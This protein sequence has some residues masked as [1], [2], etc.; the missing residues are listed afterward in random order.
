MISGRYLKVGLC[1]LGVPL[2]FGCARIRARA[3][4]ERCHY[5]GAYKSGFNDAQRRLPMNPR[6]ADICDPYLQPEVDQGYNEGYMYYVSR[7]RAQPR[8]VFQY[9]AYASNEPMPPMEYAGPGQPMPA[10]P[11][12]H[13][14][15]NFSNKDCGFQCVK[16]HTEIA[17]SK[18]LHHN[19]VENFGKVRCGPNCRSH[20][21][22]I[23][24]DD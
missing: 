6:F 21:S 17:C 9:G 5:N 20:F 15:T 11:Q 22:E 3:R 14:E 10:G 2:V 19:C 8:V 16:A 4:A 7:V 23:Q 18:E 24:C 1:L 13:C 12:W